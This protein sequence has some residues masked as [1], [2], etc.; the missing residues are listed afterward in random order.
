MS[1][2]LL[3]AIVVGF[4][5]LAALYVRGCERLVGRPDVDRTAS[6]VADADAG[7]APRTTTSAEPT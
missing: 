2:V 7:D 3:L 4:F 6:K 1:D 5:A